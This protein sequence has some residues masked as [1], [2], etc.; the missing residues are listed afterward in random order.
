MVNPAVGKGSKQAKKRTRDLD[1]FTYTYQTRIDTSTLTKN[2]YPYSIRED[3]C[4]MLGDYIICAAN[5][6]L[7]PR[8]TLIEGELGTYIVCDT[9][10][11]FA[12]EP[13]RLEI[14]ADWADLNGI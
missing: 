2:Q 7:Y 14:A 13:T 10:S 9:G 4:K 11:N 1:H 12:E 6:S 3:G 5:M 8:G